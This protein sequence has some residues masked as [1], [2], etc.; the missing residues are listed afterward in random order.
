[1]SVLPRPRSIGALLDQAALG[2]PAIVLT[3][4]RQSGK[5]TLVRHHFGE[6]HRYVSLD[7]PQVRRQALDD[8]RLLLARFPPPVV[9]DEIQ[10]APELLHYVKLDIDEHRTERG[11]YVVTG[12]Q[13]FQL[14]KGVTESL[15]GRAAVLS[16]P[17]L[18][19][20]EWA[21]DTREAGTVS[22]AVAGLS[23]RTPPAA[24]GTPAEVASRVVLGG[25]PEP[26]WHEDVPESLWFP[27]YVST[28]LERDVRTLRGVHD[29]REFERFLALLAARSPGL[30]NQAKLARDV[31]V[32]RPTVQDWLSVV[33]ASGQAASVGPWHTNLG[34]RLVRRPRVYF[35]DT[36]LL[37]SLLGVVSPDQ[38]LVG[39]TAGPLFETAVY[40]Q[41][42]RLFT[43]RGERPGI[44]YWRT[45]DGHEVDFVLELAGRVHPFE[46]KLTATPT[47]KHAAPVERLQ[48][49]L[50]ERAGHGYVVCL[51]PE[52]VPLSESVTAVPISV[53]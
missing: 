37:A 15:A 11:R 45:A 16:L 26:A 33:E 43:T 1:M 30:L 40:N 19:L 49:L 41:L 35:L 18:G 6:T 4:P 22:A 7:D 51:V 36:G 50:G 9:L 53:L 3:G 24:L 52:P 23:E 10:Y 29:L 20:R 38:G 8:P 48:R 32:S 2:F 34:K 47:R 28:Y 27:S 13:V 46:A 17:T 31:G 25:F 5:T 39:P 14:M 21:G 42:L 44:W 12:S